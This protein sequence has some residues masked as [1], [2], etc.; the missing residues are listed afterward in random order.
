MFTMEGLMGNKKRLSFAFNWQSSTPVPF[1]PNTA[2]T[3]VLTG[4]MSGTNTIYSNIQDIS[5]TDNQGLEITWSGNPTGTIS[6]LCSESGLYFYPLTFN[7]AIIQPTGSAGGYLI[8]LNQVPWR[9]VMVQYVN[10][11]GSGVL[12]MWLGSKDLN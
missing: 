4:T 12:T 5:N 8:D 9:Y 11:S 6:V 1:N 2:L 3:G 10:A 7:P